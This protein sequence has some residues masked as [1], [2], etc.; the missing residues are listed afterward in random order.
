[1]TPK[2]KA[3]ELFDAMHK[4]YDMHQYPDFTIDENDNQKNDELWQN[5]SELFGKVY[6]EF[7]KKCALIAVEEIIEHCNYA[8]K[9]YWQ[10]VKQEIE[11]L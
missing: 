3:L 8:N 6:K 9:W 1:M 2:E 5:N 4:V 10:D 11:A 7:S